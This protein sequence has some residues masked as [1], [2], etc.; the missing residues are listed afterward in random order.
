[1]T[2]FNKLLDDAAAR[3]TCEILDTGGKA[4]IEMSVFS[5]AVPKV[6]LTTFGL[7]TA[8]L[9]AKNYGCNWDPAGDGPE[10]NG[11]GIAPG[12]C[13]E[14]EGCD[15]LLS[16]K[17][18]GGAQYITVRKLISSVANGTYPNGTPK[19]TTTFINCDG[20]QVSDDEAQADLWPIYTRVFDGGVCVGDVSPQPNPQFPDYTYTEEG[21]DG[22]TLIVETIGF[23]KEASGLGA[24]IFRIKPGTQERAGGGVIGGCNFEPVIYYNPHGPGGGGNGGGD[25]PVYFPDPGG[26]GDEWLEYLKRA[27]AGAAG[28]LVTNAILSLLDTVYPGD[29][30]RLDGVCEQVEEGDPQPQFSTP[31]LGGKTFTP[32]ISRLDA[33]QHLL[34]AHLGYRTP[35]CRRPALQGDWRTITFISDEK[36][37]NGDGRVI[38]RFRLS[39][40]HI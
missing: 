35:I 20:E 10:W 14:T 28:A 19:A 15:L 30:Y 4:L 39:L 1:M 21:E 3:T 17:E 22:C 25:G 24:P 9:L 13:M 18:P 11:Q 32:V 36:S 2:A 12:Q 37:P 8:A 40:I 6:S 27:L 38:K 31:V 23:G 26:E 5:L 16:R 34:Q 33:M 7:G 29:T